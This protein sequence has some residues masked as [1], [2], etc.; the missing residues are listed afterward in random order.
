MFGHRTTASVFAVLCMMLVA[1]VSPAS[2][3]T[4]LTVGSVVPI[5]LNGK[6]PTSATDRNV[7]ASVGL[8]ADLA[9]PMTRA[10]SAST[11]T[12]RGP[13]VLVGAELPWSYGRTT[14]HLGSAGY[15][16]RAEH[17]DMVLSGLVSIPTGSP[18]RE[19][20]WLFGGG[21][22]FARVG[23]TIRYAGLSFQDQPPSEISHSENKPA[24]IGGVEQLVSV[25]RR[26]AL[27]VG[28]RVRMT[29][30][31]FE[32]RDQ[33]FNEFAVVPRVGIAIPF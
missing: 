25:G 23:G 14:T 27:T 32:M 2:G 4:E 28:C 17:R 19:T 7:A 26:V 9:I 29:V 20:R 8:W 10:G 22:V 1:S 3:Q 33:G 12:R 24:V 16:A 13:S 6:P 11:A 21:V 15:V 30:R 31:S 18:G 5:Y